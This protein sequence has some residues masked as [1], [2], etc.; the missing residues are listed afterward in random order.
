[1]GKSGQDANAI[2]DRASADPAT[3]PFALTEWTSGESA[4]LTRYDGYWDESLRA[5]AGEVEILFMTDPN[6]RVN[7]LK[8]GEVDGGWMIPSDA[9]AQLQGAGTG[10]MYFGLNTAVGSLVISDLEG[11]LA[12][13]RVRQAL[14]MAMDRQG[15]VDAA[16][17]GYGGISGLKA[18]LRSRGF[19]FG[20]TRLPFAELS[21]TEAR[22]LLA[23]VEALGSLV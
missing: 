14:L 6:A 17:K 18:L 8:S 5:R 9:I 15:M 20:P 2:R 4:T 7:A 23:T 12:D 19:D 13:P 11:P 21:D 10:D 1:M 16:V 3:G 22:E